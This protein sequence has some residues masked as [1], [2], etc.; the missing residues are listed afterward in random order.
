MKTDK[1]KL[2]FFLFARFRLFEIRPIETV[3]FYK[4]PSDKY[5]TATF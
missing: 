1:Y 4:L 2:D 5:E 3:L